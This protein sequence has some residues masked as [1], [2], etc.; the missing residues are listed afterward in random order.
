MLIKVCGVGFSCLKIF[1]EEG[2][3]TMDG[4]ENRLQSKLWAHSLVLSIPLKSCD[5]EKQLSIKEELLC[6]RVDSLLSKLTL[7][8]IEKNYGA[9]LN[10]E[11]QSESLMM[12]A[13]EVLDDCGSVFLNVL[14]VG[15][16]HFVMI[17]HFHFLL[18]T[19]W[20]S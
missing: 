4:I 6:G 18:G 1:L 3:D 20:H 5:F 2:I 11:K 7:L 12:Q 14:R 10:S 9:K 16:R 19:P 15:I 13:N 8:K 17:M